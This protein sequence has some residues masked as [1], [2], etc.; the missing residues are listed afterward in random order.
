MMQFQEDKKRF[1]ELFST[2][3]GISKTKIDEYLKTNEIRNIMEHP[4]S[5]DPTPKQLSKIEMLKEMNNLYE[6]LK[7]YQTEYEI[8]SS[9]K[10]IDYFKNYFNGIKDKEKFM[11]TLI[12]SRNKIIQ[13]VELSKGTVNEAP[14]Y[15]REI[16]KLALQYDAS[17][18]LVAHNHPGGSTTPSN[19][20]KEVT[21]KI[22][23]ALKTQNISLL[24]HIIVGGQTGI[25]FAESGYRQYLEGN[26]AK[27]EPDKYKVLGQKIEEGIATAEDV[28]Q[29]N[30]LQEEQLKEN[31]KEVK[32]TTAA[33]ASTELTR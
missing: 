21:S 25:S 26:Y 13:T 16:T 3:T 23:N 6:N 24:D 27:E 15:P 11:V 12:N 1:A 18:V 2:F 30:S 10:A 33:L 19:A 8:N 9:S 28:K 20:D 29:F 31:I 17:S 22:A 4:S 14:V 32:E 5:I 7:Y